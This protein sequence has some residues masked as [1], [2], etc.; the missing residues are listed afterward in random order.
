MSIV[1]AGFYLNVTVSDSE[2]SNSTLRYDLR[3]ANFADSLT[4][5]SAILSALD[6]VTDAVIKGYTVGEQYAENALTLPANVEVEK[7]AT[8]SAIVDGSLPTKYVNVVIPAPNQGIFIAAT[9][10]GARVVDVN[11]AAIITYLQLFE[12]GG[13]AFI[14]DGEDIA[15]PTVT[16][17]WSGRK[18]HRGSRKG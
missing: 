18:T 15:D 1:S 10:S 16:S 7:R 11:D 4:A 13:Y 12:S 2:G 9:G 14:S 17:N 3:A 8:I 6:A 5:A